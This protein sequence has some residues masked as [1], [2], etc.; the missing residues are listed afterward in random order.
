MYLK[1]NL[2]HF[3]MTNKK[4]HNVGAPPIWNSSHS[5]EEKKK[6]LLTH[7]KPLEK[8][9]LACIFFVIL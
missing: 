1:V 4:S 2:V 7:F 9:L 6:T 8:I 5:A 3:P